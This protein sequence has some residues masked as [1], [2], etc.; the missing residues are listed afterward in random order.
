MADA[1]K[2]ALDD[3]LSALSMPE[4]GGW[5]GRARKDALA[6]LG[7]VGL[8]VRRDEYWR[9]T[10]PRALTRVE[11][12]EG[13]DVDAGDPFDGLDAVTITVTDG[14]GGD[15]PSLPEG[16]EVQ[17]L[18]E[19]GAPDIHWAKDLYG[20]LEAAGSRP[21]L[22]PLATLNS[23]FATD[24]LVIR[25]TGP[26]GTPV[27][28]VMAGRGD[29]ILHHVVKVEA[30]ASLTLIETGTP[31]ARANTAIEVDVAEGGV[32]H[33][34]RVDG[35]DDRHLNA[36]LF[37]RLGAEATL[38]SFAMA[39]NGTLTRNESTVEF[40]GDDAAATLAGAVVGEGR[41]HHDDTVFVTHGA[42]RCESRQVYKKVLRSGATGVFQGKILVKEGAQ[43]TDGYQISQS[44]LL[45]D[46]AVFLAKPELE[47]YADDVACSHGSTTGAIDETALFYLRSRGVPE[48]RAVAMLV[49][50]FLAEAVEE[51][52][53]AGLQER[54][55]E[56]LEGWLAA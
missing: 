45:D 41:V 21:V 34:L 35:G 29:A 19:A 4:G 23:A 37:A 31:G 40:T 12:P 13:A 16:L 55:L 36:H 18:A 20:A 54:L 22:R 49:L 43:K 6:R 53:D 2:T 15:L 25:A 14:V 50:S 56:H 33:H 28:I 32:L 38:R 8:P 47:I 9:Y 27:R 5:L 3:R 46:D 39:R 42:L 44:L 30:G 7:A 10:D 48:A 24:G 52:D 1:H 26:V 11:A 17:R 51:V